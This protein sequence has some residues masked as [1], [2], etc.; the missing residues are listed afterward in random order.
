MGTKQAD[1]AGYMIHNALRLLRNNSLFAEIADGDEKKGGRGTRKSGGKRKGR[2]IEN[3]PDISPH[4]FPPF[5][6]STHLCT[7][8]ELI[9]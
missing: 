9:D 7:H 4:F 8:R 1:M 2:K 3:F 6:L 5:F